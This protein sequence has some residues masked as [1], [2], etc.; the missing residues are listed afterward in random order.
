M[1]SALNTEYDEI[2]P[3]ITTD[4][5]EIIFSSNRKNGNSPNEVGMYDHDI[6][7]STFSEGK[8]DKVKPI[9][10]SVNSKENDVVNNLA[11]DGT[12]M[13]LHKEKDGYEAVFESMLKGADWSYPEVLPRQISTDRTNDMYAAYSHDGWSI[14]F[15][16]GNESRSNGTDI[17]YSGMRNK[18]EKNYGAATMISQVNSKFNDGPIYMAIDGK[19]MYL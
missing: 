18:M 10:G 17:M 3:S 1:G 9:R 13:L 2:A 11:F 12:K 5:S 4:G 14:F 19:T 15:A 8:W 16:R 6:Y 7:T